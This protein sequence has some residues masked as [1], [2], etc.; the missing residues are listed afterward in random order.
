MGQPCRNTAIRYYRGQAANGVSASTKSK[1]V[2]SVARSPKTDQGSI[3]IN[4]IR[5]DPETGALTDQIVDFAAD[6]TKGK[7]IASRR[8]EAWIIKHDLFGGIN[9]RVWTASGRAKQ[10]IGVATIFIKGHAAGL[11]RS[12]RK[13]KNAFRHFILSFWLSIAFEGV[14]YQTTFTPVRTSLRF[15]VG[16]TILAGTPTLFE[17][18]A[19]AHALWHPGSIGRRLSATSRRPFVGRL[20]MS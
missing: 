17:R 14:P 9:G 1:Q 11:A 15:C 12:I 8:A 19:P 6:P 18:V 7:M 13:D 4:D 5:S 20:K 16:A 3:A 10:L 2:D